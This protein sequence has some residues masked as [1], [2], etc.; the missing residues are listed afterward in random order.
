MIGE[1]NVLDRLGLWQHTALKIVA[2]YCFIG[3]VVIEILLFGVWCRPL[4]Q[5][6]AHSVFAVF[7]LT[8]L[9]LGCSA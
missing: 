9:V 5:V 3:F 8:V 2:C 7:I 1:A 4:S 6:T